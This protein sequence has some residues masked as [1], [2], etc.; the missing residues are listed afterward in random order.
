ME[1]EM[2]YQEFQSFEKYIEEKGMFHYQRLHSVYAPNSCIGT[3]KHGTVIM[4]GGELGLCDLKTDSYYYGNIYEGTTQQSVVDSFLEC[5]K[6][7]ENCKT[8]PLVPN[9]YRLK[10]CLYYERDCEDYEQQRLI[11]QLQRHILYT[12]KCWKTEQGE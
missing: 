5:K 3:N 4:P 7:V 8:C 6:P 1:R 9:C 10:A 12:Y 2:L 11:S